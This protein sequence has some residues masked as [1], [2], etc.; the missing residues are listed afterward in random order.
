MSEPITIN[1]G[2]I[3]ITIVFNVAMGWWLWGIVK[4]VIAI[5]TKNKNDRVK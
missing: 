2:I 3:I 4:K 5:S 1:V